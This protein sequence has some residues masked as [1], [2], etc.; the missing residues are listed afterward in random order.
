MG[1]SRRK[2]I[3][4][5]R[6]FG[7][8]SIRHEVPSKHS[9]RPIPFSLTTGKGGSVGSTVLRM[10]GTPGQG[11]AQL[12]PG[13]GRKCELLT[14]LGQGGERL[15]GRCPALHFWSPPCLTSALAHSQSLS[16]SGSDVT[17]FLPL[18]PPPS[19]SGVP[20]PLCLAV[21][22]SHDRPHP[23][24]CVQPA[25]LC[26]GAGPPSQVG[27]GPLPSWKVPSLP[28]PPLRKSLP[29]HLGP[30][31]LASAPLL[32]LPGPSPPHWPAAGTAP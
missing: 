1:F 18:P 20:R 25:T 24:L 4:Q 21:A 13:Q 9:R 10:G 22:P 15:G 31:S 3:S 6:G 23:A 19:P 27:G 11:G 26:R 17:L 30:L 2:T 7:I 8:L 29:H 28:W 14:D 32:Q 5:M 16:V 12:G